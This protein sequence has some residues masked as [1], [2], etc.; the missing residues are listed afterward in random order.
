MTI[1]ILTLSAGEGD[2]NMIDTITMIY[3]LGALG[4][5][6]GSDSGD[7]LR[8]DVQRAP[9]DRLASNWLGTLENSLLHYYRDVLI[10]VP[11][12]LYDTNQDV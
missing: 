8:T 2:N 7:C 9:A 4:V 10:T 5:Q 12:R 1:A 6:R 3:L 11:I